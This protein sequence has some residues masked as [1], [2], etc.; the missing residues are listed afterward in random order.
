MARIPLNKA[1]L[2]RERSSL[3]TYNQYLPSLELKR[4]QLMVRLADE[5][6]RLADLRAEIGARHQAVGARLPMLGLHD[7][8]VSGLVRVTDVRLGVENV[9]GARLPVLEDIRFETAEYGLFARP[10]WVDTLVLLLKEMLD[11]RVRVQILAERVRR[12][13][14]A[15]TKVTQRV[16]LFEKVL[17]PRSRD[18]IHRI[19]IYLSDAERAAVVR[20]KIAKSKKEVGEAAQL[21]G[22]S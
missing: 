21:E 4:Q 8:P 13:K 9:L 14:E 7:I 1:S 19:Q 2:N 6:Q 12:L 16:N 5:R 18:N 22:A 15:V 17:I 3:K 20:S 10:H 11:C